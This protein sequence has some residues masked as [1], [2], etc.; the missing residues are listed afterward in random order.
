MRTKEDIT[1]I[2][3]FILGIFF[4]CIG[5]LFDEMWLLFIFGTGLMI[6]TQLQNRK[7]IRSGSED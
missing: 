5:F 4:M 6:Y 3:L 1:N 7:I 2:T